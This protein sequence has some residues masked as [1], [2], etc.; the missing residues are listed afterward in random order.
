MSEIN[1]KII[2]GV[3]IPIRFSDELKARFLIGDLICVKC[4]YG[5]LQRPQVFVHNEDTKINFDIIKNF[6]LPSANTNIF[7]YSAWGYYCATEKSRPDISLPPTRINLE[8][9]NRLCELLEKN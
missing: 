9:F 1:G 2:N 6:L 5:D 3:Y 8:Q 7:F 4:D